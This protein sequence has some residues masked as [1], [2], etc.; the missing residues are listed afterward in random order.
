[1]QFGSTLSPAVAAI[2]VAI[3][4]IM[5]EEIRVEVNPVT[6]VVQVITTPTIPRKTVSMGWALVRHWA[7][8]VGYPV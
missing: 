4:P 1:M 8:L 6:T 7:H 5:A 2:M 3:V